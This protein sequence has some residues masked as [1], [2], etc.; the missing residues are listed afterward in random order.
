MILKICSYFQ[1]IHNRNGG[2]YYSLNEISKVLDADHKILVIGDSIPIALQQNPNVVF[3]GAA[4]R[5][6]WKVDVKEYRS[7]AQL[8]HSYDPPANVLASILS[9]RWRIPHVATK[10]GGPAWPK[11]DPINNN[12]VVFQE[13]DKDEFIRRVDDPRLNLEVIPQRVSRPSAAIHNLPNPFLQAPNHHGIKILTIA[14][15]GSYYESK[16]R[17]A[18][19]LARAFNTIAP[20]TI[21]VIGTISEPSLADAIMENLAEDKIGVLLT[22]PRYADNASRYIQFSDVV[23]GTGRSFVE[24]LALEKCMFCPISG[25]NLPTLITNENYEIALRH[26]FTNRM[27]SSHFISFDRAPIVGSHADKEKYDNWCTNVFDRDHS[28]R[29]GVKSLVNFYAS[30]TRP[31][32]ARVAAQKMIRHSVISVMNKW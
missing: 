10:P 5:A 15:I 19:A 7:S 1:K 9:S 4:L 23:V 2:H 29:S 16:I 30:C 13:S 14:R 3:K 31:E 24:G 11:F 12:V 25:S 28:V 6:P 20:T 8:V 17:G 27:P 26:N 22:E 18:I 21:V 32:N